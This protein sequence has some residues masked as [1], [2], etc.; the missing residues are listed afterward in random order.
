[1]ATS[2]AAT[3]RLRYSMR[4]ADIFDSFAR[5]QRAFGFAL[6]LVIDVT[7]DVTA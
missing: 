4:H 1:M 5:C 6:P 3:P 2:H 7:Y